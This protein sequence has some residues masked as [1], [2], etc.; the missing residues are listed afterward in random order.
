MILRDCRSVDDPSTERLHSQTP[1]RSGRIAFIGDGRIAIDVASLDAGRADPL[2]ILSSI[3]LGLELSL[4]QRKGTDTS[5]V[6][7]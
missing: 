2:D 5:I 6:Y 4:L 7:Q 1:D 3:H